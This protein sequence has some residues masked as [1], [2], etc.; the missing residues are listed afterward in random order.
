MICLLNTG[1]QRDSWCVQCYK[2]SFK[3]NNVS[4]LIVFELYFG[5]NCRIKRHPYRTYRPILQFNINSWIVASGEAGAT[6]PIQ[7]CCILGVYLICTLVSGWTHYHL[8]CFCLP[9]FLNF[10]FCVSVGSSFIV[11][12]LI[13]WIPYCSYCQLYLSL[14]Y[15]SMDLDS[16]FLVVKQLNLWLSVK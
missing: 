1:I 4:I 14:L 11:V 10:Y 15:M 8:Q 16:S 3:D 12:Y 7:S 13:F 6:R 5:S 2:R 9:G